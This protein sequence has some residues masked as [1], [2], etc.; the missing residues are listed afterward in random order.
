MTHA[1]HPAGRLTLLAMGLAVLALAG[2]GDDDASSR[3][4]TLRKARALWRAQAPENYRFVQTKSCFCGSDYVQPMRVD[5]RGDRAVRA[6]VVPD[7][8]LVPLSLA[9]S[10]D[11]VFERI[12]QAIDRNHEHFEVTYDPERGFPTHFASDPGGN[13]ADAGFGIDITDLEALGPSTGCHPAPAEPCDCP[14]AFPAVRYGYTAWNEAGEVAATGCLTLTV[15]PDPGADPPTFRVEGTR[16]INVRCESDAGSAHHGSFP[17]GGVIDQDGRLS[18]DLNSGW[19]DNNIY[20]SATVEGTAPGAYISGTWSESH[21]TGPIA[22]GRFL[23]DRS[24]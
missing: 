21:F 13:I 3:R 18:L 12:E 1:T 17:V 23:L 16:C 19:A 14:A 4:D 15:T 11:D 20:L 6:E 5:V 7:G 9:L 2:C 10:I 22:E 24:E 8:R